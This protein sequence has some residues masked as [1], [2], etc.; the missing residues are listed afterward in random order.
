[1]ILNF[2]G[3]NIDSVARIIDVR[4]GAGL[5]ASSRTSSRND[6]RGVRYLGYESSLYQIEVDLRLQDDLVD[7]RHILSKALNVKQPAPLI[8]GDEPDRYY[9]AVPQ[10]RSQIAERVMLGDFTLVFEVPDGC[11]YSTDLKTFTNE[12]D[13]GSYADTITVV[14]DGDDDMVLNLTAEFS[15]DN[16]FFALQSSDTLNRLLFGKVDQVDGYDY[17]RSELLFDDH[18]TVDR[19]WLL[20]QGITPPVTSVRDQVGTISY[21]VDQHQDPINPD[22]GYARPTS[23]GTGTSWHGPSLTKIIPADSEGK[24]PVNFR[25]SYRID[26]NNVSS[27]TKAQRGRRV[28]HN[29]L[30][31]VDENDEIIASVVFEDND[32]VLERSDMSIYIGNERV[33]RVKNTEKFYI[34][35]RGP[36]ISVEKIGSQITVKVDYAD[37]QKSF[38]TLT[39]SQELRKITWYAAAYKD[40]PN[41]YNNLFRAVQTRKHNVEKWQD[42]PN[43]FADGDVLTYGYEGDNRYVRVNDLNYIEL[44]DVG[45]SDIVIPPGTTELMIAVSSFSDMPKVTLEGRYVYL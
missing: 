25:T 20:N 18:F 11:A 4:R 2:N 8:F 42:L 39:P 16:G 23:Y 33:W 26:F 38:T 5:S 34:T 21:Q 17:E 44:R 3:F 24:Y 27:D 1:M 12:N 22:E 43:V 14:N 40:N 6:R 13:D 37:T 32:P 30:T 7:K 10:D 19:G 31:W 29:S 41:I 45:S 15:S 35:G 36:Y 9:L 28:G